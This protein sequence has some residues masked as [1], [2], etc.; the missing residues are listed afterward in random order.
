MHFVSPEHLLTSWSGGTD[1]EDIAGIFD[2]PDDIRLA[3]ALSL[4][5]VDTGAED[6]TVEFVHLPHEP[7]Q[8]G[9]TLWR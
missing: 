3:E 5:M 9:P 8:S 6:Y 2:D 1:D 4:R 7:R